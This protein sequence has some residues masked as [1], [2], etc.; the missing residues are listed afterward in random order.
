M[1]TQPN[2]ET[3]RSR[4][5]AF[6]SLE[7][8][9]EFWDTHD[10]TDFEEEFEDAYDEEIV[11][12][13]SDGYLSMRMDEVTLTSLQAFAEEHGLALPDMLKRWIE[14]RLAVEAKTA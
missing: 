7:E 10:S 9:A 3:A 4:I 1:T 2:D 11:G 12:V 13:L 14:E 6:N 8:E 5:P